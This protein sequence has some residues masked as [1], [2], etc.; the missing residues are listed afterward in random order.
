MYSL[1][2]LCDALVV[3]ISG[4][5]AWQKQPQSKR[6]QENE[7]IVA[8]IK[9][10]HQQSRET[11]GSPRIHVDLQEKGVYCS[12][13]RVA[14][15]MRRHQIAAKRKRKF[16]TTT[17]SNHSLSVAE[18]RLNQEF[19]ASR[20]NEK[21]VTDITYIWTKEGWLYLAVVLDLFSRKVVGWAM[22]HRMGK[23]LVVKALQM[24]L[25]ARKPAPGLLHH[26][27]RG[28]QYASKAYQ[29][30]LKH[31]QLEC[32]MSRR[33]NCYDNAPMESFFATLK[34]ELVFHRQYQTR[35]EAKADIF[36]YI[37]VWYNRKRK[38]SALGYL[39]PE[40]FENKGQYQMAA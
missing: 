27:D 16:V 4:Y 10:I 11:Y 28:S 3:S 36:E 24:A 15:L 22:D 29:Q 21:W 19:T 34:Q 20:P 14:R 6:D 40:Q 35:Q 30:L 18:N 7:R 2:R 9:V 13:N 33:G 23:E 32:S 31:H 17:D 8:E 12:E 5:Y 25:L 37:Q 38:H 39:S 1:E 26:S